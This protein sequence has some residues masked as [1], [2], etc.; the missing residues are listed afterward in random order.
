MPGLAQIIVCSFCQEGSAKQ[1]TKS[2]KVA[3]F[4]F[5]YFAGSQAAAVCVYLSK[6]RLDSPTLT[7]LASEVAHNINTAELLKINLASP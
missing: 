5:F 4:T 6:T 2:T 1:A 7:F 3:L